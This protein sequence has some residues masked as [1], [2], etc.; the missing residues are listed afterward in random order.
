MKSSVSGLCTCY[1]SRMGNED[2]LIDIYVKVA[3]IEINSCRCEFDAIKN[4]LHD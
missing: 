2:I 4:L 3:I 1:K